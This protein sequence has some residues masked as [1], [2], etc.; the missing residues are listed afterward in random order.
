M[1][2][3]WMFR[4]SLGLLLCLSLF[5]YVSTPWG[6]QTE[7]LAAQT[8]AS[9]T[10][11]LILNDTS[12]GFFDECS[13]IGS[14]SEIVKSEIVGSDGQLTKKDPG[15]IT[16]RNI[17]LSRPISGASSVWS[18]RNLI[19]EGA[20]D[21]AKRDGT[22]SLSQGAGVDLAIWEVVQAW[23]VSV[24]NEGSREVVVIAVQSSSRIM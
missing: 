18:W 3:T 2:R 9:A 23:P 13:G 5:A 17:T 11:E 7:A 20:P 22:I 24:T 14:S 10:F 8:S 21:L 15:K 1:K 19:E 12:F 4:L 16:Y 6:T